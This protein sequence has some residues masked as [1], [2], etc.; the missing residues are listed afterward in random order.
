MLL[1]RCDCCGD[2]LGS[3]SP[4]FHKE[5]EWVG[6]PDKGRSVLAELRIKGTHQPHLCG[7]CARKIMIEGC[8]MIQ[9]RLEADGR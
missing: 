8:R 5:G 1:Y 7:P 3:G 6:I 9:E 2:D 4:T